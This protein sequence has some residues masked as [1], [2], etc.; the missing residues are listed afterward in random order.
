MEIDRDGRG[1][2]TLPP[3]N[4]CVVVVLGGVA[5]WVLTRT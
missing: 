2:A 3:R 5:W 4:Q 1:N